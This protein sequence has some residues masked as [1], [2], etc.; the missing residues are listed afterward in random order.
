MTIQEIL[1]KALEADAADIF[2]IAGLPVTFKCDGHQLRLDSDR[3]LPDDIMK[4][5]DSI[6]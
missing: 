4:L 1:Q 6:Y 3:L 5:V 2:L